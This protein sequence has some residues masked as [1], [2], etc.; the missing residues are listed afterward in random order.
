MNK[1]IKEIIHGPIVLII[2]QGHFQKKTIGEIADDVIA[3]FE[4]LLQ[5]VKATLPKPPA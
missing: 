5:A 4:E 2:A 1:K 3:I